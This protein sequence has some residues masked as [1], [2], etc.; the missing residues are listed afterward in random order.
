MRNCRRLIRRTMLKDAT[1]ITF[2]HFCSRN[3]CSPNTGKRLMDQ[4]SNFQETLTLKGSWHFLRQRHFSTQIFSMFFTR[5]SLTVSSHSEEM[6]NRRKLD[7]DENHNFPLQSFRSFS[8]KFQ[9][10]HVIDLSESEK[11]KSVK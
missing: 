6:W 5:M 10:I 3:T 2:V 11:R 9:I 7:E 1:R 8:I 4:F